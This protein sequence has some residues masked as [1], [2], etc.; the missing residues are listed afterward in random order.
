[1][2]LQHLHY[3][4]VLLLGSEN[5]DCDKY[6]EEDDEDFCGE[7]TNHKSPTQGKPRQKS[8]ELE[9]IMDRLSRGIP[10]IQSYKEFHNGEE[11]FRDK[12]TNHSYLSDPKKQM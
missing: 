2:Y 8:I 3:K 5:T 12:T 6:E 1:M 10:A 11:E 4:F 7:D 9:D